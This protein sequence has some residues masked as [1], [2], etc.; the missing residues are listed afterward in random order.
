MPAF[1]ARGADFLAPGAAFPIASGETANRNL[2]KKAFWG[3]KN[4]HPE[5]DD[6]GYTAGE[7]KTAEHIYLR[8]GGPREMTM[9]CSDMTV[10][11]R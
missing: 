11:S 10:E 4:E 1:L 8:H 5:L 6:H 2:L 3:W 9:T 7:I